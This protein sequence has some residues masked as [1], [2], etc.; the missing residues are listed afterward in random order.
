MVRLM[1]YFAEST[2][3][4]NR[5]IKI[6]VVVYKLVIG[7]YIFSSSQFTYIKFKTT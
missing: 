1:Y 2:T 5:D 6:N 7:D 4:I 3:T